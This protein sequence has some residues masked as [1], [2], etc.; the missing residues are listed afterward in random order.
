MTNIKEKP[1]DDYFKCIKIP[2]KNGLKHYDINLPKITDAV[3]ICNKIVIHTLMFMK[4]YLLDYYEINKSLPIINDEFV[5][6]CIKI[7]CNESTNGRPP[8]REIKELKDTL[9]LYL[10]QHYKPLMQ[11]DELNYKHLNT[12]LDY[13]TT[14]IITMYENNIKLHYVEY[15]ERFVNV[16]WKKNIIIEKI[17]KLNFTKKI[18]DNKINKLCNQL[19]RIKNDILNV[20][21]KN[22]KSDKSYHKWINDIKNYIIP[23]KELFNKNNIHYDI[24]CKP[25]DYLPCM[26]YMMK[27][28]E[29][30]GLS[31]NNVFPLRNDIIPKHIRIDTTTLVHLLMRK[32]Q[33]NK[34]DYLTKGNLKKNENKIWEF[35][36]RTERKSFKK[37][38]YTFHHMIETDGVS[39]SIVFIRNDLIGKR[40][41]N[42]KIK[43]TEKYIDEL[44]DY[45][46]LQN[47]K[48]VAIDPGKCD[49]L[50]CVNGYNKNATTFRYSQDSRRK[51]IKSK[52][53]N[54]LILEF[55]KEKI[56]DKTIIEYETELSLFNKKSLD[57]VKYKEYIKKKNEIN[58]KLFT[59]Y[60]KYI[61]R[62]LK[63]NGYINRLKNEQKLMNKFEKVF[64]DKNDVVVCFGDFEQRKHMKCKEPIKGK[65]MRTLFRKSG[66]ETYLVDEFRTSCKCCNCNGGDC[67]KFML[68]K[69][70]KPWKKN[71]TLV[72]GLL[73]CKSGCGLWNRDTN[74]AKNIY[75]IAY[76]HINNIERPLYLSRIKKSD[77]LHD[78]S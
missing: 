28:I 38:N 8:K 1:P 47:K 26:I 7:L 46:K 22:Y 70:P 53:Y 32:K 35:F 48:I 14:D 71:N 12:V 9:K 31:I 18:I 4:L 42:N 62:K 39:C 52:K 67:E 50:Y 76:N 15:V 54:K 5:N 63:L 36:F 65:G 69:N 10:E 19:R 6:S 33:G 27:Y 40:I 75:K 57:I 72:H 21:N 60:N 64:G 11:N 20:E 74:G 30:Y 73:R 2:I 17:R 68:R 45:T 41:P 61:F 55:K 49:I 66:Y 43:N 51:E 23:N 56:D 58:N 34:T 78:V 16:V 29:Q 25:Q 24:E 77:T 13:L 59:F 37:K 44:D 3:I